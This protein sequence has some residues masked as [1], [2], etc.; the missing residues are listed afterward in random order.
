MPMSVES[1]TQSSYYSEESD[2]Q[3]NQQK[4]ILKAQT[5]HAKLAMAIKLRMKL[6]Q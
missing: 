1:L 3:E 2:P 5:G 6:L 4:G